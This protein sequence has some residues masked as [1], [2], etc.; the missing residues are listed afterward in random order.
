M[1]RKRREEE[2]KENERLDELARKLRE[3]KI[4]VEARRKERKIEEEIARL[5]M[6]E[7]LSRSRKTRSQKVPETGPAVVTADSWIDRLEQRSS[8]LPASAPGP[9]MFGG[10]APFTCKTP[11]DGDPRDWLLFASRFQ[12]LV[13]DVIPNDAQRLAILT[14][15]VGPNVF[16]RIA[17]L[18]KAPRGYAAV[19]TYLKKH[20]GSSEQIARCQIHDLLSLPG[21]KP[22]LEQGGLEHDLISAAN[23]DQAVQKLPPFVRHRW[24]RYVRKQSPKVVD[25]CDLDHFLEE[26]VEEERLAR[27]SAELAPRIEPR[28]KRVTFYKPAIE[29][30]NSVKPAIRKPSPVR[31]PPT[32]SATQTAKEVDGECPGCGEAH[33]LIASAEFRRKTPSERALVAK[34]KG[35][36]FNCLGGKH[37]SVDCRSKPA[38]ESSGCRAR[39]HS[40]LRGAKRV[41]HE[42]NGQRQIP[43]SIGG[44]DYAQGPQTLAIAPRLS[45]DVLF[46]VVPVRLRAGCRTLDVFALHD[47]DSQATLLREDAAQALGLKGRP[48]KVRFGTFHGKDPVVDTRLVDFAVSSLGGNRFISVSFPQLF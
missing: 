47:T 28:E 8:T 35:V 22:V 7:E 37:R 18:R 32:V 15:W 42:K 27:S 2:S 38:C 10:S 48:R 24:A 11:F 34:E 3:E 5:R 9:W 25:L 16:R 20:Y 14:D 23:L 44:Q 6:N 29:K 17:P 36:C 30:P 46:A 45:S 39:H 4:H 12:A 33:R 21:V 43:P 31:P 13:H 26:V 41:F 40:L 19:L 1:A